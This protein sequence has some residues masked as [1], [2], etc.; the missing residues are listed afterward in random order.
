VFDDIIEDIRKISGAEHCAVILADEN[1]C[2]VFSRSD[3]ENSSPADIYSSKSFG[4]IEKSFDS[5]INSSCL[6]VKDEN[7]KKWLESAYPDFY[8]LMLENEVNSVILFPLKHNGKTL[9][10]LWCLNY[11]TSDT[12]N[13]KET[14]ELSSH[15]IASEISNYQLLKQLEILSSMDMLTGCKNR[16]AMNKFV[17]MTVDGKSG[18]S[19]YTV[20][21][22]DLNGLK[23]INDEKGHVAGDA[24]IRTAAALLGQVFY[25]AEIYRAGGD[26]FVLIVPVT[27]S[28]VIE[29]KIK[30]LKEKSAIDP[31]VNFAAGY[32]IVKNGEDI[33]DAMKTADERVYA[34]KELY[35][36]EHPE[37]KYR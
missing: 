19:E 15:L 28:G 30:Q 1:D 13:I 37:R 27:D 16:N 17:D 6:I 9:G 31:D 23:R 36:S 5:H 7:D 22:A 18:V 29:E 11:D 4:S 12:V 24:V 8:G 26:E 32:Y 33:R 25:E 14:L 34:D 2:E 35:Y 21:F 3:S 20:V 10:Y